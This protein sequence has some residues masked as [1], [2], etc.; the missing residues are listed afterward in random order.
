MQFL[1]P[2]VLGFLLG[3]SPES[4]LA[5]IDPCPIADLACPGGFADEYFADILS[6]GAKF[7]FGGVLFAM[8][9][10]Y[11][12]K[13][14]TGADNDSTVSEAYNAYAHAAIG[15]IM[16][17]GAFFI[18][19]T[20]ATPGQL[21]DSDAGNSL[22]FGVIETF[23]AL[24][25]AAL[26][27]NIF[28]QGFRLVV[29]QDDSQAEKAKKQFI[30][31]MVGAAIVILADR[32]VFAFTNRDI[33]IVSAEAV[34]IANFLGTLLGVFVVVALFVGGLYFIISIDESYR[35]RGR[36]IIIA[37]LVVLAVTMLSLALIRITFTAP[38]DPSATT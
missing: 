8:M 18:A 35:D 9:I 14:I 22:L 7:A 10:Y 29:S 3:L 4:I 6:T 2:A 34:G 26:V 15:T 20:F 23:R 21:V 19:D 27:F 37:A 32:V 13:L 5:Q 1:I 36:K 33:S 16:A 30:Y 17:G 24:L 25:F 12:F 28:Y 11:G 31:G 38:L